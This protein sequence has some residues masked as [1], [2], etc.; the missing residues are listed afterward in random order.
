MRRDVL[1]GVEFEA[2]PLEREDLG[3]RHGL[4]RV[5]CVQA[6]CGARCTRAGG[7][8]RGVYVKILWAAAGLDDIMQE[9]DVLVGVCLRPGPECTPAWEKVLRAPFS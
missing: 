4:V 2:L 8:D 3:V 5:S 7:E 6:G 1:G 9:I